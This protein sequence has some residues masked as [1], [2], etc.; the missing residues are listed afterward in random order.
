MAYRK[1]RVL[2]RK[3][4]EIIEEG[5]IKDDNGK[6]YSEGYLV[7]FN[8]HGWKVSAPGK[9][10]LEAYNGALFAAKTCEEEPYG[11]RED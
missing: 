7:E 2:L 6:Y 4:V 8:Y 1:R 11:G 9:D 10:M 3:G 5:R